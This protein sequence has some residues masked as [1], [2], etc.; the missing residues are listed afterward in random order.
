MSIINW[1]ISKWYKLSRSNPL[2]PLGNTSGVPLMELK[3]DN[4]TVWQTSFCDSIAG[5]EALAKRAL[6]Q[7]D[8]S[9]AKVVD[10]LQLM[11]V[12]LT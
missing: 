10:T 4:E 9:Q 2:V 12:N 7:G 1:V 6:Y 3:S 5:A 11:V 8:P